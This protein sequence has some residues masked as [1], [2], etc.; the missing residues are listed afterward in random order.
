MLPTG[1]SRLAA[2][3][4]SGALVL[5]AAFLWPRSSVEAFGPDFEPLSPSGRAQLAELAHSSCVTQLLLALIEYRALAKVLPPDLADFDLV[6]HIDHWT[7]PLDADGRWLC[8]QM[9]PGEPPWTYTR[10]GDAA[11]TIS[12]PLGSE[13]SLVA[14]MDRDGCW[15]WSY[16]PGGGRSTVE[17]GALR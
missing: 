6:I 10:L 3:G 11:C 12:R 14:T 16:V 15:S 7:S 5:A 4:A 2:L 9:G 1:R 8:G 17:L 13:S